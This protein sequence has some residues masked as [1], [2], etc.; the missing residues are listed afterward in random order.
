MNQ[1]IYEYG[2]YHCPLDGLEGEAFCAFHCQ[3]S[4]DGYSLGL[5]LSNLIFNPHA[6]EREKA[7]HQCLNFSIHGPQT[8]LIKGRSARHFQWIA[9]H[10]SDWDIA[11]IV[12]DQA[13]E[14]CRFGDFLLQDSAVDGF[15]LLGCS[16]EGLQ[17]RHSSLVNGKIQGLRSDLGFDMKLEHSTLVKCLVSQ[18]RFGRLSLAHCR[19][20]RLDLLDSQ[21][22]IVRFDAC[23]LVHCNLGGLSGRVEMQNCRILGGRIQEASAYLDL[24]LDRCEFIQAGKDV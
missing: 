12:Q 15:K 13:F 5:A 11:M 8:D 10:F 23:D 14:D 17:V 3:G 1:C 7:L 2:D 9:C 21:F 19:L 22:D 24:K 20:E 16:M 18:S 6:S 4:V